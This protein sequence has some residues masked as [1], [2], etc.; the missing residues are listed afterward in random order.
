MMRLLCQGVQAVAEVV[1]EQ[2]LRA[3]YWN[4]NQGWAKY[5]IA[6]DVWGS[7]ESVVVGHK[8]GR[9]TLPPTLWYGTAVAGPVCVPLYGGRPPER[10]ERSAAVPSPGGPYT[11]LASGRW[12]P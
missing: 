3:V 10:H 4:T 7:S 6:K 8:H 5:H 11:L 12:H 9:G 2:A 1:H